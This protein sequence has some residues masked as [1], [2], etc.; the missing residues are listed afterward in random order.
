[1]DEVELRKLARRF[2]NA[3][4]LNPK[5][6]CW[7][8]TKGPVSGMVMVIAPTKGKNSRVHRIAYEVFVEPIPE[9]LCVLHKCDNRKCFNPKHL[10]LGTNLDNRIGWQRGGHTEGERKA[11]GTEHQ[12]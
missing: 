8:W 11:S 5:T 2:I 1:M 10:F 9:G 4:A 12:S 7:E 6:G 3:I